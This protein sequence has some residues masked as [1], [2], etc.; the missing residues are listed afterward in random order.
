VSTKTVLEL[1]TVKNGSLNSTNC[2]RFN[3]EQIET[4]VFGNFEKRSV[5]NWLFSRRCRWKNNCCERLREPLSIKHFE[6][7]SR[8][9]W[10]R[11][12]YIIEQF[13]GVLVK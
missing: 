10:Q 5:K 2:N 13:F 3:I 4:V 7:R 9:L 6:N 12:F 11:F 1:A 8:N